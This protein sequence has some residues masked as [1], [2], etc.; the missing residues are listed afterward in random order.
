MNDGG[1][2]FPNTFED[3]RVPGQVH[4]QV[5]DGISKR[6]WFAGQA[7]IGEI[8]SCSTHDAAES[9]ALAAVKSGRSVEGQIAWQCYEMADAMLKQGKIE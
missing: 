5:I 6:E 3:R 8:A 2:A 4:T 9:V 1:P 7:L